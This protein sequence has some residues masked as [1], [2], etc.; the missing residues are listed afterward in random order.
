MFDREWMPSMSGTALTPMDPDLGIPWPITI[1]VN[2]V[3]QISRKDANA[4][5]LA[6]LSRSV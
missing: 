5:T 2:N 3:E 1:D 4:P 6:H